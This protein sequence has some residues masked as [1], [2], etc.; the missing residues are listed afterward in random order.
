MLQLLLLLL[1][2]PLGPHR[3]SLAVAGAP[4]GAGTNS[5]GTASTVSGSTGGGSGVHLSA[6]AAPAA[7]A[8]TSAGAGASEAA[9]SATGSGGGGGQAPG[10]AEGDDDLA[11]W[12]AAF[13]AL[14]QQLAAL[15]A[16]AP[17]PLEGEEG[18][19]GEEGEEGGGGAAGR[20]QQ[21]RQEEGGAAGG[22]VAASAAL[23]N[24]PAAS[25]AP[26]AAAPAYGGDGSGGGG[27]STLDGATADGHGSDY[28]DGGW[29][30][31]LVAGMADDLLTRMS[32]LWVAV[33]PE[34]A[35]PPA[36]GGGGS[37]SSSGGGDGWSELAGLQEFASLLALLEQHQQQQGQQQQ[38]QVP[39]GQPQPQQQPQPQPQPQGQQPGHGRRRL[40]QTGPVGS[41]NYANAFRLVF[42][43]FFDLVGGA[44]RYLATLAAEAN[45]LL[46]N[47]PWIRDLAYLATAPLDNL[48][49]SNPLPLPQS[50]AQLRALLVTALNAYCT[51][52]VTTPPALLL[53][54]Y[55]GPTLSLAIQPAVCPVQV[56]LETGKRS[57][58]W[59]ACTPARLSITLTPATYTGKYYSAGRYA[60]KACRYSRVLGTDV[61]LRLGGGSTATT[62]RSSAR[63][64]DIVP[65]LNQFFFR[66]LF[67]A[68]V[69]DNIA[70]RN[71]TGGPVLQASSV[72][73]PAPGAGTNGAVVFRTPAAAAAAAAA[74]AAGGSGLQGGGGGVGGGA[75]GGVSSAGE[76]VPTLYKAS[77]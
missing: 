68:F 42:G 67:S 31:E 48:V 1:L 14:L 25:A 12:N 39:L 43:N 7:D 6:H 27:S 33:A 32:D 76:E 4:A 74:G 44:G 64:L 2:L 36:D 19:A 20:Q 55:K 75:G 26:A 49:N 65:V 18:Q 41:G 37:S 77:G 11:L 40:H 28:D 17:L 62:L 59:D 73:A 8:H 3:Q 45:L 5:T 61:T 16:L 24:G 30:Q 58:Q 52:E 46:L 9:G 35:A 34:V 72:A 56:D 70:T 10:T 15:E 57:I 63:Q 13:D 54:S 22:S 38:G 29:S 60:G 50:N 69:A 66:G 53:G 71:I 51:P 23:G 47:L 21:Q